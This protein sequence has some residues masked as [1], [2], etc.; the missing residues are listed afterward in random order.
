MLIG[1]DETIADVTALLD[2]GRHVLLFGPS[3]VGKS[4]IIGAVARPGL[5]VID[6][7]AAVTRAQAARIRRAMDRGTICLAAARTRERTKIGYV[8]R[9]LWRFVPV[10]V[11]PLSAGAIREVIGGILAARSMQ[12]PDH[13]G[14]LNEAVGVSQGLPGYAVQI[15]RLAC[16][17]WEARRFL[18]E[19]GVV[20]V[21]FLMSDARRLDR[22]PRG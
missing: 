18:P 21:E 22:Q 12:A 2:A 7:F 13:P 19:P 15:A 8:G 6:P 16:D 10:R 11:A 14:W 17:R 5:M 1:R 3:Q 4:A 9:V 20:L